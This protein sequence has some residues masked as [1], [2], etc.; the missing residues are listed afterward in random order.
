MEEIALP[1]GLIMNDEKSDL[2]SILSLD[3]I[4]SY[5]KTD[6]NPSVTDDVLIM[7]RSAAIEAVELFTGMTWGGLRVVT[8][9]ISLPNQSG[10]YRRRSGIVKLKNKVRG[11]VVALHGRGI[12]GI[13]RITVPDG[14][15]KIKVPVV[16]QTLDGACCFASGSALNFGVFATYK[17]GWDCKNSL[18]SGI[19]LGCLKFISW[20][21]NNTGSDLV[22]MKNSAS[23]SSGGVGGTNS[24]VWASGAGELWRTYVDSVGMA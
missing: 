24:T 20:S 19:S 4:R 14:E 15:R 9:S 3:L 17:T 18:P 7:L 2:E 6:D 12:S 16:N 11:G 10:L 22:T 8:E 1:D 5:T 23:A 21:I 13:Y